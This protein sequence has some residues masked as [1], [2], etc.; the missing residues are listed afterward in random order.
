MMPCRR[1]LSRALFSGMK[2]RIR[3]LEKTNER[4]KRRTRGDR[5]I[6]KRKKKKRYYR[7]GS[8]VDNFVLNTSTLSSNGRYRR[9]V[10]VVRSGVFFATS[11]QDSPQQVA[12]VTPRRSLR[13]VES[14]QL[15]RPDE[16]TST[17]LINNT[18]LL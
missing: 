1:G 11:L 2:R 8:R 5:C 13:Y 16:N 15:V 6:K 3:H 14:S 7:A 10:A 9:R 18:A 12:D 4:T 17:R